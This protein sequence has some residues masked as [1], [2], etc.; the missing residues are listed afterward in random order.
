[1]SAL[2]HPTS[3]LRCDPVLEKSVTWPVNVHTLV[4]LF[5]YQVDSRPD[6]TLFTFQTDS[7]TL[8]KLTY[9]QAWL[10]SLH[11]ARSLDVVLSSGT[12]GTSSTG[13]RAVCGIWL[14]KSLELHLSMFGVIQSGGT[15][16]GFD[17]D[18]PTSR[19]SACLEDSEA[20]I[21]ICDQA[22]HARAV[23]AA[24]E[25]RTRNVIVKTWDELMAMPDL[26]QTLSPPRASDPAY[27]IYTSG[28]T[29]TP[30]GIAIPHSAALTFALSERTVLETGPTDT[31]WQGFSPAFDM[32]IEEV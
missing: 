19:V 18:A 6:A 21:L 28:S 31:V 8:R 3:V 25:A 27:M 30:K 12:T 20:A 15:W 23:E 32:F 13:R 7:E 17:P 5:R 11:L 1:M 2:S 9:R 16:L 14:E 24:T 22:H 4:D 29:G 10:D 26:G